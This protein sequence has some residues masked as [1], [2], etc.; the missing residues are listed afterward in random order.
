MGW[1]EGASLDEIGQAAPLD[2]LTERFEVPNNNLSDVIESEWQ[3][4]LKEARNVGWPEYQALIEAAY[5][6]PKL[7]R[8]YPYTSHCALG[9]AAAPDFP[10]ATPSFVWVDSPRGDGDYTV[11]E[12]WGGP[13]LAQCSTPAQAIAIAVDRIP[14]RLLQWSPNVAPEG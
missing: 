3:W 5:A 11:R 10:F 13:A 2:V 1:A 4:M 7:R 9:F 14:G 8:L 6:E 12:W